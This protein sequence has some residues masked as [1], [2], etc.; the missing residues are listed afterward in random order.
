M[1]LQCF[2]FRHAGERHAAAVELLNRT[3]ID[4]KELN[5]KTRQFLMLIEIKTAAEYMEKLMTKRDAEKAVKACGR[6]YGWT[7]DKLRK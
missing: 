2:G 1:P 7:N 3:G 6:L 4:K 5:D